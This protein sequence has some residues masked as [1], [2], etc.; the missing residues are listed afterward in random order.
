MQVF[1]SEL[2][3]VHLLSL[4]LQKYNQT[5]MLEIESK[6]NIILTIWMQN[7]LYITETDTV[8]AGIRA[9][10]VYQGSTVKLV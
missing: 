6:N 5:L 7:G 9:Y 8:G 4:D 1:W 2:E 10:K 3:T